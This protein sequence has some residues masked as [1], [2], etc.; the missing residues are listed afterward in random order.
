[1]SIK[2]FKLSMKEK[3]TLLEK[4]YIFQDRLFEKLPWSW[5]EFY[6]KTKGFF[7]NRYSTIKS[8]HLDHTWHDR[9]QLLVYTTFEI[10]EKFLEEECGEDGTVNWYTDNETT[11]CRMKKE[12]IIDIFREAL[13]W[14][15]KVYLPYVNG[16]HPFLI[17]YNKNVPFKNKTERDYHLD[18][19]H[20]LEEEMESKLEYYAGLIWK[21]RGC[22]WT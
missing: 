3:L 8:R 1:M 21:F 15:N 9:D 20:E 19:I 14:W 5:R 6:W 7:W 16:D 13:E 11:Y 4:F 22:M 12:Y 18:R 17:E 2:T 10:L